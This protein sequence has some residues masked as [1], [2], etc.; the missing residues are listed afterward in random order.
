VTAAGVLV[1]TVVTGCGKKGPPLAPLLVT[2]GRIE[3]LVVRRVGDDVQLA[4]TIPNAN[5]DGKTPADVVTV[6]AFALTGE[7]VDVNGQSLDATSLMREVR[8][9]GVIEVEPPPVPETDEQRKRREQIDMERAERGEPPLP[10]P[11]VV[12]DPRPA[13][14]EKVSLV[15]RLSPGVLTPYVP[16]VGKLR[17]KPPVVVKDEH[18]MPVLAVEKPPLRRMYVVAG[19][20]RKGRLGPP[21]GRIGLP[22]TDL[23]PVPPAPTVRHTETAIVVEWT[24]PPGVRL[25]IQQAPEPK[26]TPVAGAAPSAGT[27]APQAPAVTEPPSAPLPIQQATDPKATPA[28]TT[29]PAGAEAPQAPAVTEPQSARLL[30]PGPAPHAYNVYDAGAAAGPAAGTTLPAPLNPTPLSTRTFEDGRLQFGVERC[31]AV[32][33]VE[34]SAGALLESDASPVACIT[35]ADTF[36][37]AAPKS[38]AAVGSEGAI[39]LIWEPSGG[40][41]L[42]GYIVLRG[43]AGSSDPLQ[44][45]TPAPIRETTFRDTQ[46]RAG[47]RYVYAVVAVDTATPQNVSVESNRV[48]ETAR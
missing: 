40:A 17:P 7:P 13:Q 25:P 12:E 30:F 14:G 10:P 39:N 8:S 11:P 37:P 44:A 41:D 24:A 31:Y 6:E 4:F 16:R 9:V 38:L 48:E 27:E 18:P 26:A 29:P 23:P 28:V 43:E 3:D 36:P 20:S 21:S 46:V 33:T 22:L 42:A 1:L 47:K 2:P 5:S 19:R 35:P 32:R 15:E 34:A 45:L